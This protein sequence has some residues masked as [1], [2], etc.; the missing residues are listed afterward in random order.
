MNSSETRSAQIQGPSQLYKRRIWEVG[1]FLIRKIPRRILD[2]AARFLASVYLFCKPDRANIVIQNL[3]PA[4]ASNHRDASRATRRLFGNFAVKL[5]DLWSYETGGNVDSLF[6]R[7]TG[8]ENLDEALASGR[9]VLIVT[10]HLGNWEFG[11]PLISKRGIPLMVV[12][13]AEPDPGLTEIRSQSRERWGVQTVVIG[14]NPFAFV[15]VVRRLDQGGVVAI[16]ID[17]PPPKSAVTVEF[18]GKKFMGSVAAAELARATGCV[19]LPVFLPRLDRGYSANVLPAV[20]Y[21][22]AILRSVEERR[23]LTQRILDG[24]ADPIRQYKEQW[25]HFVSIWPD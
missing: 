22:R 12:T 6:E 2:P 18:F 23:K 9:G 20:S 5:L 14:D 15:E 25:Y 11:A 13:L 4:C 19:I 1:Y 17:R 3:L 24:F 7:F 21:D 8:I 16:L 10:P